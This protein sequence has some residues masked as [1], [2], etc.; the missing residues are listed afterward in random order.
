MHRS[1]HRSTALA[2]AAAALLAAATTGT[3][4]LAQEPPDNPI[5]P[6]LVIGAGPNH[7]CQDL[8]TTWF[9]TNTSGFEVTVVNPATETRVENGQTSTRPVT[10][11]PNPIQASEPDNVAT[12]EGPTL[13]GGLEAT[14][15]VQW[16][17]VDGDQTV[18]G[19]SSGFSGGWDCIGD[20]TPTSSTPAPKA[21]VAP[22]AAVATTPAFTG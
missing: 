15:T 9:V 1:L 5:D 21:T 20:P 7:P 19:S 10:L 14:L 2:L 18:T 13:T 16:S 4:A 12:A 22:T 8:T 3:A 17:Y 6:V 11:S